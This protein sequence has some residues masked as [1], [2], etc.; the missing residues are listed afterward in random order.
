M[1]L[2]GLKSLCTPAMVYLALSVVAL[3]IMSIQNVGG[4]YFYCVGNY[5][6]EASSVTLI[7][8]I[9]I[10]Y[11]LFW[12]WLLNIICRSGYSIVSWILVLFPF[13]LFFILIAVFL[14]SRQ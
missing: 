2:I 3:I 5:N 6:C 9:K 1:A 4:D 8:I 14:F 11:I 7:F 13:I 12:T 10:L